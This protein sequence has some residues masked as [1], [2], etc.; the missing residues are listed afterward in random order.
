[1]GGYKLRYMPSTD[2]I[3]TRPA[4][5][6]APAGKGGEG[7]SNEACLLDAPLIGPHFSNPSVH[8]CMET[9]GAWVQGSRASASNL[10]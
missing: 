9:F 3:R 5:S 7:L 10:S 6:D 2:F 8:G 1:M 4:A